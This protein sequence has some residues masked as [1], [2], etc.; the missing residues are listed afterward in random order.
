MTPLSQRLRVAADSLHSSIPARN[1]EADL[2]AAANC[3]DAL[4]A[5]RPRIEELV[6]LSN[7][8]DAHAGPRGDL[9]RDLLALLPEEGR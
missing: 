7:A 8:D 2:R 5:L 6:L 4:A 3:L 1:M 9:W